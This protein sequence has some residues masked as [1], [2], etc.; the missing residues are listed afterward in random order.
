MNYGLDLCGVHDQPRP[1]GRRVPAWQVATGQPWG[2]S[3]WVHGH[4]WVD[5]LAPIWVDR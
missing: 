1:R 4:G 5:R 2:S 3:V